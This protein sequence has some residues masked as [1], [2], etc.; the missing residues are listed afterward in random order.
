LPEPEVPLTTTTCV[1]AGRLAGAP[2]AVS[3]DA[4]DAGAEAAGSEDGDAEGALPFVFMDI[5]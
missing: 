4:A 1:A 2:G 3:A 5:P